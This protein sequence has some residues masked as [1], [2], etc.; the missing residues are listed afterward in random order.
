[1]LIS[2]NNLYRLLIVNFLILGYIIPLNCAQDQNIKNFQNRVY[3]KNN[4]DLP[5]NQLSSSD[6]ILLE[7]ILKFSK[8]KEKLPDNELGAISNSSYL[9]SIVSI[10]ITVLLFILGAGYFISI[11]RLRRR[12]NRTRER[13]SELESQSSS[14]QQNFEN[15][16]QR[17]N[18]R[19]NL[20]NNQLSNF[21]SRLNTSIDDYNRS[22]H[23][24]IESTADIEKSLKNLYDLSKKLITAFGKSIHQD[25]VI[26]EEV[27]TIEDKMEEINVAFQKSYRLRYIQA[28][29]STQT[30]ES[31][32]SILIAIRGLGLTDAIPYLDQLLV[33]RTFSSELQSMIVNVKDYLKSI[34]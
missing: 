31:L 23:K 22:T 7:L 12:S 1:M 5:H 4:I 17:L 28:L 6:S 34:A 16:E 30:E 20:T 24:Y 8:E 3:V 18:H 13:V 14:I 9:I 27:K 19:E 25:Q 21:E 29:Q 26:K 11:K 10:L 32:R 33:E 2:K 15:L